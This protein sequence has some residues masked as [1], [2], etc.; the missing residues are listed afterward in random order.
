MKLAAAIVLALA[1]PLAAAANDT[2]AADTPWSEGVYRGG[3][4]YASFP[5]SHA[6]ACAAECAADPGC[7]AFNFVKPAFTGE[8]MG[9]CE[10]KAEALAAVASACCSAGAK[11]FIAAAPAAA[12]EPDLAAAEIKAPPRPQVETKAEPQPAPKPA[13]QS[14]PK[15]IAAAAEPD[16]EPRVALEALAAPLIR[17]PG[18]EPAPKPRA[19]I[20][21]D[22]AAPVLAAADIL[23]V[24][25]PAPSASY[26]LAGDDRVPRYSVQREH[27]PLA[28]PTPGEGPV[29]LLDR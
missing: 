18:G 23:V 5:A 2:H 8:P 16:Q 10:L 4:A 15:T 6:R 7:K 26:R 17:T 21:E 12:P 11:T 19:A 27:R 28:D 24:E 22:P 13:P 14:A 9:Q 29:S 20:A 25:T 3:A 1:A